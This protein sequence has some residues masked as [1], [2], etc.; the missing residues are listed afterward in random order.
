VTA[1]DGVERVLVEILREGDLVAAGQR[2]IA[3]ERARC[4]SERNSGNQPD[5]FM[6][7]L[8]CG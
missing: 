1:D 8:V 5:V 4:R 3:D 2:R 6:T 7:S